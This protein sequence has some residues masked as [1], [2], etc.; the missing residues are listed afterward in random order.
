MSYVND[1]SKDVIEAIE[2]FGFY[3]TEHINS[4]GH[5]FE[6]GDPK[7]NNCDP[8]CFVGYIAKI[9]VEYD[10]HGLNYDGKI[11]TIII[12]DKKFKFTFIDGWANEW[13]K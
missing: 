10:C 12:E 1:F 5:C 11:F 2:A 8:M 4:E 6:I 3:H 7:S 9:A 13:A